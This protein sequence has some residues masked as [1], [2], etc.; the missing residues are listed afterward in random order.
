[1]IRV[2]ALAALAAL[3]VLTGACARKLPPT[4][5]PPDVSPPVLL[6]AEP[7]SGAVGV[8]P[9]A[10]I[11][12]HFSEAMDRASVLASIGV[13][14][15][16]RAFTAE[17]EG[18]R[19]VV[20][21]P[22]RLLPPDRVITVIVAPGPRDVRGNPLDRPALIHFAT[23]PA[24]P[25]GR[26]AGRVE[27]RG[28]Q[29]AGVYVWAYRDDL[30]HVPDSTSFDMD[31]L[32]QARGEG[33]FAM[34]GLAVPGRYR[35]WTFVDRNRNRSYE[36]GSDLLTSSP[37]TIELTAAS[38]AADSAIALAIDP[39]ALARV[40]GAVID[41]LAPGSG[42]LRVEARAVPTDS[43]VAADRVPVIP[44]D[45]VQG[46]FAGNLRAGRWRLMAYR[47]A[48]DDRVRAP[49]EAHSAPV[50]VDLDPGGA[51]Q[52]IVLVLEPLPSSP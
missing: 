48:D 35:L 30:G 44:I 25:P 26:I 51:A 52:S 9:D 18:G 16:V 36:P 32:A 3:A 22:D 43:A 47:D 4:G 1:V 11:R 31:A 34:P 10:A 15:G 50:E 42:A 14:P 38:P 27:G 5:G 37:Q 17:W 6:A 21:R 29:P 28:V 46:R 7:D 40:E 12:L 45:V 33:G 2:R 49:S 41:S 19:T 13:G 24:F 39:E 23:A 8:A 20:L